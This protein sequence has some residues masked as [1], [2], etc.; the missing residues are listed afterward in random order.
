ME[1]V[2]THRSLEKERTMARETWEIDSSHSSIHFSVRHMVVA[3]V[4]GHFARWTGTIQLE[5]GDLAR[6]Q[7][8]VV[9]DASSIETGVADRDAHLR[10][11][12]FFDVVAHPEITF[13][14]K[15]VDK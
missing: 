8:D 15:R 4:R 5:E 12:D 7:V 14:S 11:S 1:R 6:G 2:S 9:I 10:S 3:K 13:K